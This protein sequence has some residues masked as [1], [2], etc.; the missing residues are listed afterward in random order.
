MYIDLFLH[1]WDEVYLI[2]FDDVFDVFVD[3]VRKYFLVSVFIREIILKFS[4]FVGSFCDTIR[5]TVV[6]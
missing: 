4:F 6:S 1:S 2:L 5:V 3:L